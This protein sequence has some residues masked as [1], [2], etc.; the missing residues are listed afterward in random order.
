MNKFGYIHQKMQ[1]NSGFN[2][3]SL[4]YKSILWLVWQLRDLQYTILFHRPCVWILVPRSFYISV[5]LPELPV[6]STFQEGQK[7]CHLLR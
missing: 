1:N 7:R 5:W 2:R 6:K 3:I 4:L